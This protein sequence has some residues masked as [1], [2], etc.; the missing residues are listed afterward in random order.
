MSQCL[1]GEYNI[2]IGINTMYHD[3]MN[4]IAI[5]VY[6]NHAEEVGHIHVQY[7]LHCDYYTFLYMCQQRAKCNQFWCDYSCNN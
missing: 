4:N 3:H 5:Y 6:K 1:Q 7:L 2:A